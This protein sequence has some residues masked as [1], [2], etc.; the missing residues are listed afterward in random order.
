MEGYGH[1][2][3]SQHLKGKM[4]DKEE[5][6]EV[7]EK[8]VMGKAI[9]GG[10]IQRGNR[11]LLGTLFESVAVLGRPEKVE[12]VIESLL[13]STCAELRDLMQSSLGRGGE[14]VDVPFALTLLMAACSTNSI[15]QAC[16]FIHCWQRLGFLP[17]S[18]CLYSLAL[19]ALA[20]SV[21]GTSQREVCEHMP[22]LP[23]RGFL[24]VS[25]QEFQKDWVQF[26][27]VLFAL[28]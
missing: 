9:D 6:E 23:F 1:P 26:F 19:E 10:I 2:Q 20:G 24:R 25:E 13:Q 22:S 14:E 5:E 3:L 8:K 16:S 4:G 17:V 21:G 11:E 18:P 27:Y 12:A 7:G 28:K 15:P